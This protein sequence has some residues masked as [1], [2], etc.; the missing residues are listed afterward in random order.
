MADARPVQVTSPEHRQVISKQDLAIF[1]H[2][3]SSLLFWLARHLTSS[4]TISIVKL[5]SSYIFPSPKLAN[6]L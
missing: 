5:L 2:Y 3:L 1:M 6:R 4:A